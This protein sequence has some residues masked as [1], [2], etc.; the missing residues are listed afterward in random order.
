MNENTLIAIC[1][2]AGD[3]HQMNIPLYTHHE[4]P[5]VVLSPVDSQAIVDHPGVECRF[6]GKRAYI[7]QDSLDRQVEH[8]KILLTYPHEFFMIHDS[9]SVCLDAE[10]PKYLYD[11]PDLVWSNQ[12]FD[13]IP[14][15]QPHIPD[16]WPKVAFQPPY[17]LSR[18]TIEKMLA[19]AD[20]PRCKA[21]PC[22][23]FIDFFMVQLTM[24][25]GLEW[26]RFP[27]CM[28]FGIC[29][30]PQ[31]RTPLEPRAVTMYTRNTHMALNAVRNEGVRIVHS[32]KDPSIAED[33]Y[34]ARRQYLGHNDASPR[35][36]LLPA[37]VVGGDALSRSLVLR[38]QQSRRM[39]GANPTVG[40]KA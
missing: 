17:F 23:P 9:D 18:K 14:E 37:Q 32:V 12:V 5:V 34:V 33:L 10:L 19:V 39:T 35:H 28:S 11:E 21:S 16:G 4:C 38:R 22:M 29:A 7:G 31:R 13:N 27:D 40:L 26:R 15:H 20:D 8:L 30:D 24:V 6:G 1:C 25:A 36:V 2:Y 3:A